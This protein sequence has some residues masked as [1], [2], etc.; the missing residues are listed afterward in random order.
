MRWDYGLDPDD[1]VACEGHGL[2]IACEGNYQ[3]GNATLSYYNPATHE[4]ENEAFY[5][6][7]A[8]KLGDVVQSMTLHGGRLWTV[9][10]NSHVV[11][12][13]DAAS[14]RESGRIEGLTSPR[15]IHFVTDRKAYV[16][17]L[18]DNR[19][20]IVDPADCSITGHIVTGSR[21]TEQMVA[22]GRYVYCNCWSY[23]N[24]ILRIDTSTD[25]VTDSLTVGMQPQSMTAD[26][27]GRLWVLTDGGYDGSP[28]GNEPPTLLRINA[29]TMA[30]EKRFEL[31]RD[32]QAKSVCTNAAADT[33]YWICD[34]VWRMAAN[35]D[36]LPS[37]PFIPYRG[38]RF[39]ELTVSPY[40][41]DVYVA[42]AIDYQQNGK[43]YRYGS[44]G[45]LIDEFYVGI[46]PGAFCWK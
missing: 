40:D 35:C 15:Y 26:A 41:S 22:I 31:P 12:A 16:S 6:A 29:E 43:I 18:Y 17:Q 34:D 37:E 20:F 36:S 14:L 10:N 23:Q 5:R 33:I 45:R 7:N 13:V 25:L 3:Y 21:S 19:I 42:D 1:T 44:D 30:V 38:T 24:K 2:F 39:Y 27:D 9:V 28:T 4:V 11:F 8:M 32:A 46:T